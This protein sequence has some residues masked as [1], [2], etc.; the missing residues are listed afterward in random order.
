[1]LGFPMPPEI[2]FSLKCFLTEAAREG[3]VA[4]VLPEV[5]DEIGGLTEGFATDDTFVRL[6]SCNRVK[7]KV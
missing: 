7:R 6:L 4:S 2:H 5:G 3:L 1:M